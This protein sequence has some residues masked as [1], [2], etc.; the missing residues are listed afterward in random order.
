MDFNTPSNHGRI[1]FVAR[2]TAGRR[3]NERSSKS[4]TIRVDGRRRVVIEAVTPE[5]D[6]GRFPAKRVVGETVA[7]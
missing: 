3:R 4:P 5:I 2:A 1:S 6:G 7:V